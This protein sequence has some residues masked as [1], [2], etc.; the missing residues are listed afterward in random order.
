MSQ[1]RLK[2]RT[3]QCLNSQ[4]MVLNFLN[5]CNLQKAV[6]VR[7]SKF[8]VALVVETTAM[9]S[10]PTYSYRPVYETYINKLLILF[11]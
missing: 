3:T 10:S 5:A 4:N 11:M 7:D 1:L 6:K 8:G 9:V 2:I